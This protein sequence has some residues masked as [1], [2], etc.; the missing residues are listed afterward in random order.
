VA[1][2][3]LTANIPQGLSLANLDV[4]H[5]LIRTADE[6]ISMLHVSLLT[7]TRDNRVLNYFASLVTKSLNR[8]DIQTNTMFVEQVYLQYLFKRLSRMTRGDNLCN[9]NRKYITC[10]S[11]IKWINSN[12][13]I[14]MKVFPKS[15]ISNCTLVR[16]RSGYFQDLCLA[17][18]VQ[19]SGCNM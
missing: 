6:V 18:P 8:K 16:E 1:S 14:W 7:P 12:N 10:V 3:P 13:K 11:H 15:L 17:K 2:V 4:F 5:E 19:K 9:H